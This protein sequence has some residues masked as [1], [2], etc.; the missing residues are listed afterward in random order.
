METVMRPT[1][2]QLYQHTHIMIVLMTDLTA[3]EL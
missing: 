3:R 2:A 1:V